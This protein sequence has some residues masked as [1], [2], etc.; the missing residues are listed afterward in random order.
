MPDRSR[1]DLVKKDA[2]HTSDSPDSGYDRSLGMARDISRRGLLDGVTVLAGSLTRYPEFPGHPRKDI[3]GI[4]V[5]RWCHRHSDTYSSL[6]D[7]M[8]WVFTETDKRSCVTA[9]QPFGC[10]SVANSDAAASPHTDAAFLTAH[11]A[12]EQALEKL[13]YPFVSHNTQGA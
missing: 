6:C 5:N 13:A 10:I 11:W 9:R 1:G 4:T 8:D 3:L 7:P 12:V 2:E